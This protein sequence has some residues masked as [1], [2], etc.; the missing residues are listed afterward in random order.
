MQKAAFFYTWF[1]TSNTL[2][3]QK[4]FGKHVEMSNPG[5]EVKAEFI[6]LGTYKHQFK[7]MFAMSAK[8]VITLMQWEVKIKYKF[9]LDNQ[10]Q[11]DK[12]KL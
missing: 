1:Q 9:L 7:L 6:H 4:S 8:A 10:T 3:P 2:G 5:T 11:K 12:D